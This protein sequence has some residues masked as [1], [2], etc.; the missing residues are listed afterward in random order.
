MIDISVTPPKRIEKVGT[1]RVYIFDCFECKKHEIRPEEKYLKKHSGKCRFCVHKGIPY[2]SSY[3]HLKDGVARTNKRRRKQKSFNLSFEE[4]LE[5]TKQ[6]NCHYCN[7]EIHWVKH[8]GSGQHK[9]NLDRKDSSL[10]YSKENCVVCCKRC[11]YMKGSEFSHDE[12]I[13]VVELIDRLRGGKF[14][15]ETN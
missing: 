8:T 5:F 2:K 9:Y 10:G 4:F 1:S 12:F 14:K 3:N 11:N 7:S 13:Q 6:K 15:Y